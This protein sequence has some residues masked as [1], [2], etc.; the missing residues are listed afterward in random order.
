MVGQASEKWG[1]GRPGEREAGR[2]PT[3]GAGSGEMI[4]QI[5]GK[6]GAGRPGERV[7]GRWAAR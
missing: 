3:R 4:G 1:D 7:E 6:R 5:S 2:W